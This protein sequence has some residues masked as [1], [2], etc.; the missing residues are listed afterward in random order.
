MLPINGL[1]T[2]S[3]IQYRNWIWKVRLQNSFQ[4]CRHPWT[5]LWA[6][7]RVYRHY[8]DVKWRS[9]DLSGTPACGTWAS[10]SRR[11]SRAWWRRHQRPTKCGGMSDSL[12]DHKHYHENIQTDIIWIYCS[13]VP[14]D[15]W[16]LAYF[17]GLPGGRMIR[18]GASWRH[19]F[20][21]LRTMPVDESKKYPNTSLCS[22]E[23]TGGLQKSGVA[24]GHVCD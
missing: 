8:F 7:S 3:C 19:M 5:L 20:P 24:A 2:S 18:V 10:D 9:S 14:A 15:L 6:C 12:G 1:V 11:T 16:L 22:E 21:C 17:L 13:V 23:E 4:H